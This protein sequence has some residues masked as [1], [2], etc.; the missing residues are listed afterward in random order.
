MALSDNLQP[1]ALATTLASLELARALVLDALRG[2]S[3]AEADVVLVRQ[4]FVAVRRT[5]DALD[6]AHPWNPEA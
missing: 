1:K 2:R 4:A 6:E 3:I 5:L